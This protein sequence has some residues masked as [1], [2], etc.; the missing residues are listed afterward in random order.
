MVLHNVYF[1]LK[2]E[3][4]ESQKTGFEKGIKDFLEAVDEIQRYEIGVPATTPDR[5]VV[6]HSFGVSIF[7]WFNNVED[8]NTYQTHEAH[9][10]FIKSFNDLW[11][12][13]QVLDSSVV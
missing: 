4:T 12:K 7:V 1:W 11:A 8:H 13:V 5:D 6:D 9:D 3:V 10:V 2:E